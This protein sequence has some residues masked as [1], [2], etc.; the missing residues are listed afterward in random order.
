MRVLARA[1]TGELSGLEALKVTLAGAAF[2]AACAQIGFH[3]PGNP[4]VPVTLQ[5]FAV[6]LCGMM[7]GGRLGAISQIEY[8]VAGAAGAPVFAEFKGGIWALTG[9]TGGYLVAFAAAAFVVGSIT[10]RAQRPAFRTAV[11]AG[12]LGVGV[13]YV[14]GRAWLAG[15][16]HLTGV[17][18]CAI[19]VLPFVIPDVAK[20]LAAAA[21]WG[22]RSK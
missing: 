22:A 19:G 20:V 5:V 17:Q 3:L 2:T 15:W 8:L 21:I 1:R 4:M 16:A 11:I 7:L 12:L 18:S 14:F 9:P 6:M 10:G 13:I